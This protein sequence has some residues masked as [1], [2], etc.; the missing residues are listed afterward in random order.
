MIRHRPALDVEGLE[1]RRLLAAQ[2]P[3]HGTPFPV[4]ESPVTIQAEDYDLGGEGIAY[5]DIDAKNDGGQYRPTDGVDIMSHGTGASADPRPASGW[6]T[7]STWRRPA[8]TRWNSASV[9]PMPA[10]AFTPRS[11]A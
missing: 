10:R 3:Y 1:P 4:N 6:S 11:M 7:P 2:S 5:R 8:T 9:R